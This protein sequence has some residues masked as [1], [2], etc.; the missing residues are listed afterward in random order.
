M[1]RIVSNVLN[2]PNWA[3][4][5]ITIG[6]LLIIPAILM[7]FLGFHELFYVPVLI[8]GAILVQDIGF[9]KGARINKDNEKVG[10]N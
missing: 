3:A 8:C 1:N 2:L 4:W 5:H 10:K 7:Y 9:F 6:I